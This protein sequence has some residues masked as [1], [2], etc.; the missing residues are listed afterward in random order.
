MISKIVKTPFHG[1]LVKKRRYQ[2]RRFFAAFSRRNRQIKNEKS[3]AQ[4]RYTLSFE[5]HYSQP[6][7]V[8]PK[9]AATPARKKQIGSFRIDSHGASGKKPVRRVAAVRFLVFYRRCL[10]AHSRRQPNPFLRGGEAKSG[11]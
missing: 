1:T 6:V 5:T 2:F 11:P 7:L 9:P 3:G 8:A 4:K 10:R